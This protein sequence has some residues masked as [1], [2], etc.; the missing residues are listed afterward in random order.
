MSKQYKYRV[1]DEEKNYED[2]MTLEAM[3]EDLGINKGV[4]NKHIA[5]KKPF[6]GLKFSIVEI[7]KETKSKKSTKEVE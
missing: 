4:I 5:N 3:S 1:K 6:L 7:V 2:Y